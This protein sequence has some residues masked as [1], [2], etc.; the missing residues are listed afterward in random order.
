LAA[1]RSSLT[2]FEVTLSAEP[3]ENRNPTRQRGMKQDQV[4]LAH[5]S[6]YEKTRNFK[7][8]A[9]GYD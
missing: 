8:D 4:F 3:L 7:T 2:R 9:S 6:G 1:V 5:A